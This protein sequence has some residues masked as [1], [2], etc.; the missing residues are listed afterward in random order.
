MRLQELLILSN[1]LNKIR[2]GA[3]PRCAQI[4]CRQR[5]DL[6]RR[7]RAF[8]S[9]CRC[10]MLIVFV[11][12]TKV[13]NPKSQNGEWDCRTAVEWVD[14]LGLNSNLRTEPAFTLHNSNINKQLHR[15]LSC[16]LVNIFGAIV[17][18]IC[19]WNVWSTIIIH[20]SNYKTMCQVSSIQYQLS[21]N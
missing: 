2:H 21:T 17:A 20:V 13:H 5:E 19:W 14:Y 18:A 3:A 6:Q 4:W 10:V 9:T 11:E 12:R 1:T 15:K 8:I 7:D 16:S